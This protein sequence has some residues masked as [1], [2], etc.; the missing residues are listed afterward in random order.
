MKKKIFLNCFIYTFLFASQSFSFK[1]DSPLDFSELFA[2]L[3][4]QKKEK[5]SDVNE[6][7]KLLSS[8]ELQEKENKFNEWKN[9][10]SENAK[11]KFEEYLKD[12]FPKAL[13]IGSRYLIKMSAKEIA[14]TLDKLVD[15]ITKEPWIYVE[16]QFRK[17]EK[18]LTLEQK[19]KWQKSN[20]NLDFI[21]KEFSKDKEVGAEEKIEKWMKS[22]GG[23]WEFI[24]DQLSLY[25]NFLSRAVVDFELGIVYIKKDFFDFDFWDD[26]SG[27]SSKKKKV[28]SEGLIDYWKKHGI[29]VHHNFY[30]LCFDYYAKLFLETIKT[31]EKDLASRY[32]DDLKAIVEDLDGSKYES[33]RQKNLR[34]YKDLLDILKRKQDDLP[35]KTDGKKSSYWDE[36]WE[37]WDM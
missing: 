2:S 36:M 19:D 13:P 27:V 10:R 15:V 5:T 17:I 33:E 34:T 3:I 22:G 1:A 23:L 20:Y 12:F 28:K 30:A 18:N 11:I 29:L 6:N 9:K 7:L 16:Q 8:K 26:F 25:N 14:D 37:M 24:A 31:Q 32:Y 21:K 35:Q 4:D